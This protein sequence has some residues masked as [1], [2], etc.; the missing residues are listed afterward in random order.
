MFERN[1]IIQGNGIE[2][3]AHPVRIT[4]DD[5]SMLRGRMMVAKTRAVT[6]ELN[7]EGRFVSFEPYR[8]DHLLLAKASIRSLSVTNIPKA[9]Q[10]QGRKLKKGEFD[11]Y[12]VLGVAHGAD[13][14]AVRSA[15]HKLAKTYHPDRYAHQDLP[16]EIL[17]YAC[18]MLGRINLSYNELKESH[19]LA[20]RR[21]EMRKAKRANFNQA[22]YISA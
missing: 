7:S 22:P 10:L 15:Y 2:K 11:P 12:A 21:E 20:L 14:D 13:M 16:D 19:A 6:E 5:G 1:H 18:D 17:E 4:L 9:S 8:G 3:E